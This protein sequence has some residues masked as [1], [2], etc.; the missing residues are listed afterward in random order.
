MKP[1]F[2]FRG[3]LCLLLVFIFHTSNAADYYWI[4]GSGD[5]S[6]ISH[7]ATAPNGTITHSQSP[8]AND[9]VYFNFS[10]F[11]AP[12][13][14]VS[15]STD[16]IFCRSMNWA[17]VANNPTLEGSANVT[18][19][20]YGSLSLDPN[21]DF[22]FAGKIL[23]TGNQTDN[24]IN[25]GTHTAGKDVIFSG[26]GAWT[27]TN[28]ILVD[29]AFIFN[30]GTLNTD[31]Q[32]IDCQYFDSRSSA[33]RTLNLGASIFTIRGATINA[34]NGELNDAVIPSLRLN[35]ENL[36]M[37]PGSSLFILT[38]EETDLWMEGP[39]DINFNR[40]VVMSPSG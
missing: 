14:V 32:N 37:N 18:I 13:Q 6:D 36:D 34:S 25:L 38:A 22:N 2:Y 16:I 39:G 4:G 9:D 19:S 3:F 29:S 28:G 7:W 20:I 26:M 10:S 31:G 27:L 40:V 33:Q 1:N 21:M 35:A 12:G 5:W 23:F 15:L 17:G 8:T 11:D 24:T 30:E